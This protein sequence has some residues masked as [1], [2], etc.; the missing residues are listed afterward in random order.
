MDTAERIRVL[1]TLNNA[2][3]ADLAQKIDIPQSAIAKIEIGEKSQRQTIYLN[4]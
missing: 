1:K 3:Q 2:P 4:C